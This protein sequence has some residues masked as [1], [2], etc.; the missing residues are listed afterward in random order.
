VS[1][2]LIEPKIGI[3]LKK[4]KKVCGHRKLNRLREKKIITNFQKRSFTTF[5]TLFAK[6]DDS[7]MLV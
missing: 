2:I 6:E 5:S 4:K 1:N 3:S 7:A